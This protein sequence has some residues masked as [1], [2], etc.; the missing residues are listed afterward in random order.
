MADGIPGRQSGAGQE[1]LIDLLPSVNGA[2]SV[3]VARGGGAGIVEEIED[4]GDPRA[5][6]LV[7]EVVAL[8]VDA[9]VHDCDDDARSR[10]A[11]RGDRP[12]DA[13]FDANAVASEA[14]ASGGK[15]QKE[16]EDYPNY[17]DRSATDP[18]G[19]T[20]RKDRVT[21]FVPHHGCRGNAER[22]DAASGLHQTASSRELRRAR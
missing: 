1:R 9:A 3:G 14:G 20:S 7:A 15:D 22:T 10:H 6:I 21:G 18:F 2:V 13:R 5:A 16:G 11:Q 8:P 17:R 19:N 12:V 4:V